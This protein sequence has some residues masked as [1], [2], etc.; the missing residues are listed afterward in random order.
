MFTSKKDILL[1]TCLR[2][3]ARE[4]LTRIS[5]QTNIPVSTIFDKLREYETSLISKHTTLIDFKKIGFDI[6]INILFKVSRESRD[7]FKEFLMSNQNINSIFRVNNGY[8]FL[9]EGI[10]RG[11]HDLQ[12]F[13]EE[14]EKYDIEEKQELFVLED[15][16]REEFLSDK[17]HAELLFTGR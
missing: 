2:N 3:N 1:M 4:N 6:K 12:F 17:I 14:I 11:M 7:A 9:V 13:M 10:F 5:K 16:K 8:D 15:L